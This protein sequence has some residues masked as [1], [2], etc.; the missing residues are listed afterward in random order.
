MVEEIQRV[1]GYDW[2]LLFMQAGLHPST[3]ILAM[4]MLVLMLALPA[5]MT[6]FRE[7]TCGGGWLDE[8]ECVL[9]NRIGMVLGE[10]PSLLCKTTRSVSLRS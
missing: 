1:L 9:Q 8:T 6:R 10:A 5:A 4:R 7:G 2:L 3:V